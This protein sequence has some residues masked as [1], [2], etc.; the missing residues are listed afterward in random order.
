MIIQL[1]FAF[2][3]EKSSE[4]MAIFTLLFLVDAL[5][6]SL[7]KKL[8][9]LGPSTLPCDTSSWIYQADDNSA[10]MRITKDRSVR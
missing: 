4:N 7:K 5:P 9:S 2:Q 10:A 6:I 3:P 1:R 8:N